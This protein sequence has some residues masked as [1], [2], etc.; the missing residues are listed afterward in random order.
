MKI[1]TLCYLRR[2][3]RTLMVHRVRNE[4][5]I[6][7]GRWNGLGGKLVPGE[8]PE[9]CVTREVLEE[10]GLLVEKP[11]LR[12]ILTFPAFEGD[13]DWLVFVFEAFD[14]SGTIGD[15][16]EGYLEWIPDDRLRTLD[17]WEG[18]HVFMQWMSTGRFFSGKLTYRDGA[19][20]ESHV[21][22]HGACDAR[23]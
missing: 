19:L 11:M 6:H 13:D 9:E 2:D 21:V 5:D 1:A 12:G 18:D 20:A 3:G 17:L 16:P 7:W 15:C 23:P 14:F 4:G 22:L 8:T 10:S